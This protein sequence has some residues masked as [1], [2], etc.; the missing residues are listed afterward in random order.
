MGLNLSHARFLDMPFYKTGT[1]RKE[2]I[3]DKDVQ[4]VLDLL[5]EKKPDHIFVAG[6]L[7]DPHGTHRMC[8]FAIQRALTT[9]RERY[10]AEDCPLVL[11]VSRSLA[12]VGYRR[13]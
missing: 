3:G 10:P 1:V 11:A 9:Y 2:P 8:Y 6:D 4:I 5:E 13:S 7:S 12:G